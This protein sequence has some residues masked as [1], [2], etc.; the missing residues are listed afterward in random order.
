MA[1]NKQGMSPENY[2]ARQL[3]DEKDEARKP[4]TS[5]PASDD[6]P[7]DSWSLIQ[8]RNALR[9]RGQIPRGKPSAGRGHEMQHT[10]GHIMGKIGK[11][12]LMLPLQSDAASNPCLLVGSPQMQILEA[13]SNGFLHLFICNQCSSDID[14][15][16]LIDTEDVL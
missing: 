3:R 1:A 11:R 14:S 2:R 6:E 8:L 13:L 4:P 9:E 15:C 10:A 16:E 5:E 12:G 7:N